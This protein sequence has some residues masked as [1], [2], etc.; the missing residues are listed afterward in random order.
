MRRLLKDEVL[1]IFAIFIICTVSGCTPDDEWE[2][3][4]FEE[5]T[6]PLH[7]EEEYD[8]PPPATRVV[9]VPPLA[10]GVP[11]DPNTVFM[12]IF[13]EGIMHVWVNGIPASGSS[14]TWTVPPD[15]LLEPGQALDVI[16]RNRDGST[17]ARKVGLNAIN[18]REEPPVITDVAALGG[19][20]N[21]DP[22]VIN[23]SGIFIQFNR[24]IK[25]TI[26]LTDEAGV[27]LNWIGRVTGSTAT[28]TP[29]ARRKLVNG[30]IYKIE[31][32]VWDIDFW[33]LTGTGLQTTITFA[34]KPK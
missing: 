3:D 19:G 17:D 32:N 9:L 6:D 20:A 14:V 30:A 5:E 12:L 2:D 16:W 23:A 27:D 8:G 33:T 7:P 21:V 34:T 11:V 25:G 26:K 18:I 31:I 29:I 28:L 22:A 15:L 1:I 13:D 10:L 24:W 4:E